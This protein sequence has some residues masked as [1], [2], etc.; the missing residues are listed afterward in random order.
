MIGIDLDQLICTNCFW[1]EYIYPYNVNGRC[2]SCGGLDWDT[3]ANLEAGFLEFKLE[4]GNPAVKD[5]ILGR[6]D[7]SD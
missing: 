3:I 2:D 7:L 5:Y 6:Q 4:L 1:N